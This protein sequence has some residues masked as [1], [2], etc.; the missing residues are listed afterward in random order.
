MIDGRGRA[1][2]FL[3]GAACGTRQADGV[4]GYSTSSIIRD[5]AGLATGLSHLAYKKARGASSSSS[6]RLSQPPCSPRQSGPC[7]RPSVLLP[8]LIREVDSDDRRGRV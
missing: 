5:G 1:P 6:P 8:V 7:R 3:T 2:C 4:S